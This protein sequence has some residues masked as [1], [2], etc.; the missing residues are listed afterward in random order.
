MPR[1]MLSS[2]SCAMYCAIS[3]AS[4]SSSLLLSEDLPPPMALLGR[5]P[6]H[7]RH[8]ADEQAPSAA[9]GQQMPPPVRRD[10][11]VLGST[12]VFR[13]PPE[14]RNQPHVLQPMKRRIE[15]SVFDLQN[16]V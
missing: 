3:C 9:L 6:Q 16:V 8:G 11:V 2:V 12:V 4:S 14:G 7:P 13:G 15:R 10:S 5:R 1:A